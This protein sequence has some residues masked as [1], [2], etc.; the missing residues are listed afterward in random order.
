MIFQKF[1]P[2]AMEI[3]S[4]NVDTQSVEYEKFHID[5][6]S[7]AKCFQVTHTH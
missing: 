4:G 2:N 5:L 6:Y 7:S 3:N 1:I